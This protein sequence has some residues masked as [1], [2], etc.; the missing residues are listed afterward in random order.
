MN[1][2]FELLEFVVLIIGFPGLFL[3]L[4]QQSRVAVLTASMN[5]GVSDAGRDE[6]LRLAPLLVFICTGT[7]SVLELLAALLL[8]RFGG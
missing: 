2:C 5:I 8:E 4:T 7:I 6:R 1:C 3:D